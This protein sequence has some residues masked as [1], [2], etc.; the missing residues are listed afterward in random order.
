[1]QLVT[2]VSRA[3][4]FI[5]A[6]IAKQ[7]SV[8][9]ASLSTCGCR[10]PFSVVSSNYLLGGKRNG[11]ARGSRSSEFATRYNWITGFETGVARARARARTERRFSSRSCSREGQKYRTT[12]QRRPFE[13]RI[14]KREIEGGISRMARKSARSK[15]CQA[16]TA[17]YFTLFARLRRPEGRRDP[18]QGGEESLT[19]AAR[20]PPVESR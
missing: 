18:G 3:S 8:A 10:R 9:G 20:S 14:A 6:R 12:L 16:R 11:S 15:G 2:D 7:P 5:V 1:V 4:T 17:V 13:R 19:L